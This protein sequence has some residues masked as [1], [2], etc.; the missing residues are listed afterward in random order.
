MMTPL[1]LRNLACATGFGVVAVAPPAGALVLDEP[2]VNGLAVYRYTW[3]DSK[4]LQRSVAFKKEGSGNPG[5]G[6]YIV[7]TTFQS[8]SGGVT[9][10]VTANSPGANEGFGYFVSHERYRKFSDGDSQPIAVKIFKKDDS[11]LGSNF[12][13]GT[14]LVATTPTKGVIRFT[15]TYPRYGTIAAAHYDDDTGEDS[16]PLGKSASLYK[17]YP[18]PVTI[19]WF[20]QDGRDYPRVVTQVDMRSVSGPDRVSFDLRGPYGK[21]DFDA[22][23]NPIASV[24]WG[25]RFRFAT[26]PSPLTRNAKWAWNQANTGA[27]Y[28]ALIAGSNEMGLVE[29]LPF[30]KSQINDGY[31]VA[32]GT[33]YKTYN[34]GQGC[35]DAD[36]RQQLPCDYEWPYQSA[37]YE[38]PQDDRNAPTT[39]E[40]IA[41]G[42]TNLY[43]MSLTSTYDGTTSVP[44]A[45][46]P[47]S[48]FLTYQ[49]CMV[50]GRTRTSGL[51]RAVAESGGAYNCSDTK[52]Q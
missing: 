35:T 23:D 15:L 2:V 16:P 51:S 41:W 20:I 28:T 10:T 13:V 21:L 32:R 34:G 29:P 39:S 37:Q 44:F 42:S 3:T 40:K 5:H 22:G 52:T 50:F 1:R 45:G 24:N 26:Y 17:L 4:G 14:A 12:P 49:V 38:L 27:R 43:G 9:T 25:D 48:K 18:L 36:D 6:G 47:A 31:A 8:L 46:F 33:T 30:A 7:R 19:L 11:P